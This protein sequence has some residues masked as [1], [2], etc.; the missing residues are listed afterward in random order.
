MSKRDQKKLEQERKLA[1]IRIVNAIE[2]SFSSGNA[3]IE[4]IDEALHTASK[5]Y[6][7]MPIFTKRLKADLLQ[8]NS[9]DSSGNSGDSTEAGGI[10]W[11]LTIRAF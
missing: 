9:S 5:F 2:S 11:E 6:E 1:L 10:T 8:E 4:N 7:T 3:T